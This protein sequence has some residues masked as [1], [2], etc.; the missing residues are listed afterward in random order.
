MKSKLSSVQ[1]AT[2]YHGS[3]INCVPCVSCDKTETTDTTG[4]IL[5]YLGN[6]YRPQYMSL[7]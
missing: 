4:F 3:C 5:H 7:H 2:N 6:R 1:Q